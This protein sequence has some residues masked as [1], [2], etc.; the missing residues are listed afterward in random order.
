MLA[1]RPRERGFTYL[2]LIFVLAI[3]AALLA[4][5][6]QR[7]S[8]L[9]QREREHE[10]LFRGRQIAAA[11]AS[12]HAASGVPAQWPRGFDDLLEDRRSG[13]IRRH[14]RQAWPDPFS[15]AADWVRLG[16]EAEHWIGVRSGAQGPAWVWPED[17]SAVVPGQ[18]PRLS[19][20]RFL[21]VVPAGS[22]ASASL[23]SAP[24]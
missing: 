10:L 15:G 5:I 9:L 16:D 22:A 6:G 12:Y 23:A 1:R 19:D 20:H 11:I 8:T 24:R 7:W 17:W 14:L 13:A 3:G 4:A 18:A 2:W 21:A